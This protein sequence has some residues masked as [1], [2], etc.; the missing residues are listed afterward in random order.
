VLCCFV[1]CFWPAAESLS[2]ISRT[3]TGFL[4]PGLRSHQSVRTSPKGIPVAMTASA[5]SR[6]AYQ[7]GSFLAGVSIYPLAFRLLLQR[8]PTLSQFSKSREA[9]SALHCS[10]MTFASIYE[11]YKQRDNW[12]PPNRSS[13]GNTSLLDSADGN[14]NRRSLASSSSIIT[15]QSELGNCLVTIETAYLA[16]DSIILLVGAYLQSQQHPGGSLRK[17]INWRILGY[18]HGGLLLALG[19]LQWYIAQGREKGMLII[20]MLM[21]MNAS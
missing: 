17:A 18:H 5:P 20:L 7:L 19:V 16:Q 6:H 3:L 8:K 14:I 9:V 11:L 12:L 15:T 13:E 10:L 2:A 1:F 4:Q 21:T